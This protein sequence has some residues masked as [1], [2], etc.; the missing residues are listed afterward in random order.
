MAIQRLG[1]GETPLSRHICRKIIRHSLELKRLHRN[2]ERKYPY[3]HK[4]NTL[5]TGY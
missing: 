3:E 5:D 2:S 4:S 1:T